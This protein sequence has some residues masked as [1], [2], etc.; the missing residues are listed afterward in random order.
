MTEQKSV[1]R[2]GLGLF[3]AKRADEIK[4]GDTLVWNYGATSV[5]TGLRFSKSGK[6]IYVAQE[7]GG[8]RGERR[9]TCKSLVAYLA[10]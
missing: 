1:W 10:N 5:V 7:E 6:T 8:Y 9:H 4:I 3:V 2:Q